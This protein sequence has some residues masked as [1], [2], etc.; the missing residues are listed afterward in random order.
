MIFRISGMGELR[1]MY[2]ADGLGET[3]VGPCGTY[4]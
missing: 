4:N 3:C 2:L 1:F